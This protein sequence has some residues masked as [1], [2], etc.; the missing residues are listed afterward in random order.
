MSR[1]RVLFPLPLAPDVFGGG[2]EIGALRTDSPGHFSRFCDS[3]LHLLE[4]AQ[5]LRKTLGNVSPEIPPAY[6]AL[7]GSRSARL[8]AN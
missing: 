6:L 1:R 3:N 7:G 5:Y 8:T 4:D 2:K